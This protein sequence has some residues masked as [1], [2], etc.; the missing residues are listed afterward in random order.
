MKS[1]ENAL[2]TYISFGRLNVQ[3]GIKLKVFSEPAYKTFQHAQLMSFRC[4][5]HSQSLTTPCTHTQ[6]HTH[7][8]LS[9]SSSVPFHLFTFA[10]KS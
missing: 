9:E 3:A 7:R 1:K 6:M 8:F 4:Q 10:I 5:S 2:Q